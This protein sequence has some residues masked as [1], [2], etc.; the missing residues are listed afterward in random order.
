M[1]NV[2]LSKR[3]HNK[4]DKVLSA[5]SVSGAVLKKIN[6]YRSILRTPRYC[7][8]SEK[9]AIRAAY[10]AME[11]MNRYRVSAATPASKLDKIHDL[12]VVILPNTEDEIIELGF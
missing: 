7:I 8:L 2:R 10:E 11:Q 1:I 12:Q 9:T 4:L 3:K 5:D 6:F